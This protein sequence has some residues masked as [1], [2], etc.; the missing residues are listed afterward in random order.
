VQVCSALTPRL[1]LRTLLPE[2]EILGTD[3]LQIGRCVSDWRQVEPGDLFAALGSDRDEGGTGPPP[4]S[5]RGMVGLASL[6]PPYGRSPGTRT[7]RCA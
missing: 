7:C 4:W 2:A 6:D 1:S 5:A 3:D